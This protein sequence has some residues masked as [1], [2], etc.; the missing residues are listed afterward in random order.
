MF[1][2]INF[3]ECGG[4]FWPENSTL[5]TINANFTGMLVR[6]VEFSEIRCYKIYFQTRLCQFT[7]LLINGVPVH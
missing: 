1:M 5:K 7:K 3:Q 6:T 4:W 2:K